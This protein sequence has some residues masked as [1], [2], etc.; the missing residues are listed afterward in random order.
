MNDFSRASFDRVLQRTSIS[1]NI[2]VGQ[3]DPLQLYLLINIY[4]EIKF[5]GSKS[6]GPMPS[7]R[8]LQEWLRAFQKK[9]VI[10]IPSS[11]LF[12]L[13]HR[14]IMCDHVSHSTSWGLSYPLAKALTIRPYIKTFFL[15]CYRSGLTSRAP[16]LVPME[17]W[18]LMLLIFQSI[19]V[20]CKKLCNIRFEQWFFCDPE[21]L[22][23]TRKR[24]FTSS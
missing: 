13:I 10:V 3:T 17:A 4:L 11:S 23:I 2:K 7:S 22:V 14:C 24:V 1:T 19:S 20:Q 9:T 5:N 6:R 16:C 21:L 18:L 15:S 8:S 12:H